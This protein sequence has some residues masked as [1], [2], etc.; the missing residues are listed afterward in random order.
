M[1]SFENLKVSLFKI[2]TAYDELRKTI[3]KFFPKLWPALH[4]NLA[5]VACLSWSDN[6]LPIALITSGP[7][8]SGK[9]VP[10]MWIIRS[11]LEF[12]ERSDAFTPASF[13]S[14]ASNVKRETLEKNDLLP[15]LKDRCLC[16]KELAPLFAGREDELRISFAKLISILDGEGLVTSSGVH[17]SRGYSKPINFTWLGATTPPSNKVFALMASLG[18]RLFFFSTDMEQPTA[19][20]YVAAMKD[21]KNQKISHEKCTLAVTKF[22]KTFFAT[23]PVRSIPLETIILPERFLDLL[24]LLGEVLTRLRG[25]LSLGEGKGTEEDRHGAPLLEHGWRALGVLNALMRASALIRGLETTRELDFNFIRSVCLSSMPEMRRKTFET[26]LKCGGKGTALDISERTRMSKPTALHYLKELAV[27]GVISLDSNSDPF[28]FR[29]KEE[30]L[31]LIRQHTPP[32]PLTPEEGPSGGFEDSLSS[33]NHSESSVKQNDGVWQEED[34][35]DPSA[36]SVFPGGRALSEEEIRAMNSKGY[37]DP[38]ERT[39]SQPR[40]PGEEG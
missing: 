9:T 13:V 33:E 10:I 24:G 35:S 36:E 39:E 20:D 1:L 37:F 6:S 18:T 38:S 11:E 4:A 28:E 7:P 26:I 23:I 3:L 5:A 17:G 2:S 31:E 27:L 25:T 16:T 34:M 12:F 22:L 21:G 8:S 15:K 14:H 30:F 29:L 40:E 32:N 19:K